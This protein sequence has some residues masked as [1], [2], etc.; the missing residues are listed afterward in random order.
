M[1]ELEQKAYA[2]AGQP[3]NLN[4][5]RQIGDIFF[6]RLKLPVM[7]KTATGVPSTDEEVLEKLALDYP[8]P[9]TLLEYRA[10]SKLKSTYTDKLPRM[11]NP[12]TGRVH[13]NYG[14]ATAVTGQAFGQDATFYGFLRRLESYERIFSPETTIVLRH[15]AD[16]LRFLHSPRDR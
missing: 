3:F 8:L 4:S 9:K 12:R 16:L 5:P 7:K 2:E 15:D 1:L 14:Q 13:T 11:V 6:E 10:L